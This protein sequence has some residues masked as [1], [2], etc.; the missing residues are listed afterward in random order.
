MKRELDL[1]RE[2][3]ELND[4]KVESWGT[5]PVAAERRWRELRAFYDE[6]MTRRTHTRVPSSE[7]YDAEEIRSR[8]PLRTRL[9]VPLDMS[10]FFC[11]D[12]AYAPAR[13]VNL[14]KGGIFLGSPVTLG[15]H[16]R[17][18]L[19]MPNLGRGYESLFETEVDVVWSAE[20]E[21][22]PTGAAWVCGFGSSS[23]TPTPSS[24]TS[25]SRI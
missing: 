8:L 7:R 24:T 25:S 1:L 3:A 13:I 10:L 23:G 4:A 21:S 22:V 17:L 2:F 15:A 5:L 11:H 14:S 6:L 19:Y 9:R 16:S 12:D 20:R 18:T